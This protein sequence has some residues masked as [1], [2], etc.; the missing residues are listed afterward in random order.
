M[1]ELNISNIHAETDNA[2][3]W[4]GEVIHFWFDEVGQ[5]HWF[6]KNDALDAQIRDRF[7]TLHE[8]LGA[9]EGLDITAPR[10]ILAAILVL[11]QFSR[12]LFRNDPRAYSS[13][14]IARR[15]SRAAIAQGFD[16]AMQSAERYFIYLPFEH[17]EHREDQA[18]SLELIRQLGSEEWTGFARAHKAMIDRFGRFPH[19]NEALNRPSTPDEIA[20]LKKPASSF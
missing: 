7:L 8:R 17:S 20:F 4:V 12:N 14:A 16:G 19:R 11:D 6:K 9:H 13:D 10:P 1:P 2:P 5:A 18:L 15:L 3:A